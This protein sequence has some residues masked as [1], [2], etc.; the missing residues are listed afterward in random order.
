MRAYV[1][2]FALVIALQLPALSAEDDM[3]SIDLAKSQA[4]FSVQHI[5]VETVTGTVPISSGSV[6]LATGSSVPVSIKAKLDPSRIK[7]GEDDRDGALQTS[8]W[9]DTKKFP[10]WTFV[11]SKI[12]PGAGGA[13]GVDGMLTI[14]GVSVAE[15]LDVTTT[16]DTTHP[17]YNAVGHIDRHAFGFAV[18]RLDPVIGNPVAIDLHIELKQ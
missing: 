14:H 9:F 16:G 5:F 2:F 18:T 17:A 7:T 3:R 11:S 1:T 12:T 8:D 13:F 4:K 10:A 15:H 6:E